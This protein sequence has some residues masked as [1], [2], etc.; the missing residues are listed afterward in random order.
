MKTLITHFSPDL[1]AITACWLIQRYLPGWQNASIR[2]VAAGS[3]LNNLQPDKDP[4][5][6]HVD[7]GFGKF[8]HH[9]TINR[10]SSTKLVFRYLINNNHLDKKMVPALERMVDFVNE[11]DYFGEVFFPDPLSDVYDF[12]LHQIAENLK[13]IVKNN[14]ETI[15]IVYLLL[16]TELVIFKKKVNAEKEI[17]KGLI[18]RSRWGKSLVMETN[19]EEAVKLALKMGYSFVARRDPIRGA[20]R[21]KTLP[22]KKYDLTPLYKKILQ[23][24]KKATWFLH[25]SKNMLLNSSS[26][27]PN[28]VP[29]SL[30]LKKLIEIIGE[31]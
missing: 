24:D 23:V 31:L 2:Y 30:S 14:E 7:T 13:S 20:I 28:F 10:V 8:D 5:I 26:K 22:N 29:S 18:F 4:N 11:I 27:N 12:C 21:I 16:D 6:I 1:D 9:Q 19:N 25:V 15:K 17:K 3:T